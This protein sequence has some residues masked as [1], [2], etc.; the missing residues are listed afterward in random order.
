MNLRIVSICTFAVCFWSSAA[1]ISVAERVSVSLDGEWN[2]AESVAAGLKPTAFDHKGP[3]PGLVNQAKPSFKDIDHYETHEY[4]WTMAKNGVLPAS[5]K[6]ERLGRTH[7]YRCYFW[8]QK[9][10]TVP[11]KKD[12]AI[13]V[14]NKAQFGTAVWLNGK[15]IG[16]HFSCFTPSRFNLTDAMQWHGTNELVI[17]I[18]AHPEVLPEWVP[19][20]TDGEKASWTPGIYDSVSL[21]LMDNP[22]IESVQIAPRV[23]SSDI[24][25]Q[26]K[27]KNYGKSR[28]FELTH[29]VRTWRGNR[30][31]SKKVSQKVNLGVGEEKVVT[32]IVAM[33]AAILWS[34]ENPFLYVAQSSTGGDNCEN[35]FGLREF[36]FDTSTRR[37]LLNGK[38]CFMRGA[39]I[40][41]HRFLGDPQCGG[42]PW[43]EAWVRKFLVNI[44]RR[45]NWNSFRL[46]IGPVPQRW[47]DIAD[48]AGLL[49]QYE[50]PI[51][52]DRE[53]LRHK[54]WKED[55]V[56]SQVEEFVRDNWNHPS[57]VIWDASNET[58]WD[59]LAEKLIPTVRKLDLSNRPWENGYNLPQAPDDPFED[60]PYL[61]I[62]H[63]G[64]GKDT[65]F[66]MTE[67]ERMRGR[68]PG[69]FY[70]VSSHASIINE[71]D[72]LWLHRDGT[73][74][75]L[76]RKVFENCVGTNATAESR[77]EFAAYCLGGLT[78]F[79][80]AYRQ[81][82]GVQYLAYLDADLPNVFTCDNFRDVKRLELEPRFEYYV[83]EAF[84][85]LGVYINFWQPQLRLGEERSF[86]VMMINDV[87]KTAK[88]RL[89]VYWENTK[90]NSIIN[91]Q[92]I[93]YEIPGLGQMSYQVKIL[94]PKESGNY[95]LNAMAFWENQPWSPVV[96]RRKVHIR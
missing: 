13:L 61:F 57:V 81:Y 45:M 79:W 95:L 30:S 12:V 14:I 83:K 3:V 5:D 28:R 35:R 11:K 63:W 46:C 73:P 4:V 74:T 72:W 39:S 76:T 53:P 47:L 49:L 2:I 16:E 25:V 66:Q 85:P 52:S 91:Q 51:W 15:Q 93:D 78:E 22:V 48:E 64:S 36:K 38:V 6:C 37:A 17:R 89:L 43:N 41:F 21:Q 27:L 55:E 88:G 40:T 18:G 34:P 58:H 19:Y 8:F 90:D 29:A 50:F 31:A 42:L 20:G 23:T 26:T 10:F 69:T 24:V 92:E 1:C 87:N 96:S 68:R 71:Y 44:P 77:F 59:F 60:H 7:Q 70:P 56:I 65:P 67:L 86:H 80:R 94:S 82:A 32:D 84:K 75:V 62:N 54:L 33:P 9:T